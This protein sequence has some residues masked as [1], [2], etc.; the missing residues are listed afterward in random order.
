VATYAE[1][2]LIPALGAVGTNCWADDPAEAYHEASKLEP[3]LLSRQM[4]GIRRLERDPG[5]RQS[6]LRAGKLFPHRPWRSLPPPE[7]PAVAFESVVRCRRSS[8]AFGRKTLAIQTLST[9]LFVAYGITRRAEDAARPDRRT[10]PSAGALYPL[11]LYVAVQ[12][13]QSVPPGLY[14]YAPDRHVLAEVRQADL[15]DDLARGMIEPALAGAPAI[16]IIAAAFWRSRTKYGLRGYRFTLLEA[17][18]VA[19][20]IQLAAA[21]LNACALP[22]GGFFDRHIDDLLA[23][24][25]LHE[26]T[27]Y[28]VALGPRSDDEHG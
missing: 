13:V 26:S 3:S 16:V 5:M 24:N 12:Q 4:A 27:V 9:I 23:I 18:H 6:M 25:G 21:A 17:G 10:V 15:R 28:L 7:F 1:R 2:M 14:H 22:V 8:K 20:N 19:Q 11:D